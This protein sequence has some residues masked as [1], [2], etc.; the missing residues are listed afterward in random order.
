[1]SAGAA[2]PAAASRTAG[3][4]ASN[5]SNA[6]SASSA[7]G[8][9]SPAPGAPTPATPGG[10]AASTAGSPDCSPKKDAVAVGSV[11]EESGVMGAV[12]AASVDGVRAWAASV[13][14]RGGL[15]GHTARLL[16]ADDGGDPARA[17]SIVQK[18]VEQ[19]HVVAIL[20]NHMITT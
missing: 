14:E 11:G 19:D 12:M 6:S 13:G 10:Q 8:T 15:C 4:N 5:A 9:A 3:G 7:G 16:L 1:P 17:L 18:M 2:P 20:G